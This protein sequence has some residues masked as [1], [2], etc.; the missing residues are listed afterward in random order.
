MRLW[1]TLALVLTVALTGC[2][3]LLTGTAH[4]DA[5]QAPVAVVADGYGIKIGFDEAP[6]QLELYTEPQCGHCADLQADF[7]PQLAYY[8]AVGQLALTYRPMTFLDKGTDLHSARVA[9]ALFAAATPAEESDVAPT[10]PAFQRFVSALW[11]VYGGG[12]DHPS[13]TEL[14]DIARASG[15]PDA[16]VARIALGKPAVDVAGMQDNNFELLY[17]LDPVDTAVPSV[18]D[19]KDDDR[20]DVYDDNWLSKVM[21]S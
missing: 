13:A 6:V 21:Q 9:N 1:F 11:A 19:L 7:G 8:V 17:L 18:Y 12:P 3:R 2:S 14:A 5:N 15:I 10:G 20:L 16:R 4:P